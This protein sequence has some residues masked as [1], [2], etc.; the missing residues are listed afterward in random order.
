M[1]PHQDQNLLLVA[2]LHMVNPEEIPYLQILMRIC[3]IFFPTD[4]TCKCQNLIM[5]KPYRIK[6]PIRKLHMHEC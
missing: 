2:H 5:P 6:A 4:G 3:V 1:Y